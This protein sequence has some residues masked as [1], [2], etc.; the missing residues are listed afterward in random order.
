MKKTK[1][2]RKKHSKHTPAE[3]ESFQ[4]ASPLMPVL[5]ERDIQTM[6]KTLPA[7]DFHMAL[8]GAQFK[9]I[10]EKTK[11]AIAL[12]AFH[13]M[14]RQFEAYLTKA[15][16]N[17]LVMVQLELA[18]IDWGS[19]RDKRPET[20]EEKVQARELMV[21][22]L[23]DV[24]R[25][26]PFAI[27]FTLKQKKGIPPNLFDIRKEY[28]EVLDRVTE[29]RGERGKSNERAFRLMEILPGMD[30]TLAFKLHRKK[31]S[32]I[33]YQYIAMRHDLPSG[34]T[35]KKLISLTRQPV[36]LAMRLVKDIAKASGKI[37]SSLPK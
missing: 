18:T 8:L 3:K 29:W 4:S 16:R 5:A 30:Y 21:R 22:V 37:L 15:Q 17:F 1:S 11:D 23:L 24:Y 26:T 13:K 12:W 2:R 20:Q 28:D 32:E 10:E 27:P 7:R 9:I 31:K 25:R 35:V 34:D 19:D 6:T 36:K 14:G 33:A